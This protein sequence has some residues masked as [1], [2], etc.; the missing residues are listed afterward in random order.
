[1][2]FSSQAAPCI[3]SQVHDPI[4]AA[5]HTVSASDVIE[6]LSATINMLQAR[7]ALEKYMAPGGGATPNSRAPSEGPRDS[8]Q[9]QQMDI[10]PGPQ[11]AGQPMQARVAQRTCINGTR[12]RDRK[13][14]VGVHLAPRHYIVDK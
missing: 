2:C 7:K 6:S 13:W 9:P 12:I 11:P 5:N 1:M 4:N 10:S 14:K 3:Q 8:P